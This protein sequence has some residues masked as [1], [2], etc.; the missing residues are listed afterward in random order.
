MNRGVAGAL[1]Y[2]RIIWDLNIPFISVNH[3]GDIYIDKVRCN[4]G[5]LQQY[6]D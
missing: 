4:M 5:P 1:F 6:Y 3:L 2:Q